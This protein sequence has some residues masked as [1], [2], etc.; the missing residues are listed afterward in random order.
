[1]FFTDESTQH[2]VR[3]GGVTNFDL[4]ERKQREGEEG[5]GGNGERGREEGDKG[6]KR[7]KDDKQQNKTD[8]SWSYIGKKR[9]R[10]IEWRERGKE[11]RR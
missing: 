7:K 6:R 3:V 11:E 2:V 1:M 8:E 4:S 10:Y 5:G 9:G